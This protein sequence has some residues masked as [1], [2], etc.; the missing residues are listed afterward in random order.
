M[1]LMSV[2]VARVKDFS[3]MKISYHFLLREWSINFHLTV[4]H[5]NHF[6]DLVLVKIVPK[7]PISARLFGFGLIISLFG[8][9]LSNQFLL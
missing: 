6:Y 9:V 2:K 5:G 7:L 4:M 3:R 1:V 8:I